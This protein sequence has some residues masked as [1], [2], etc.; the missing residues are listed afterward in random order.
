VYKQFME[1]GLINTLYITIEPIIF[2]KG[3]P[4]FSDALSQQKLTLQNLEKIGENTVLLE[5]SQA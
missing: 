4:L 2:G 5:Y 3:V 1:I